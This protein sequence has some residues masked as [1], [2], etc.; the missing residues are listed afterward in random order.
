MCTSGSGVK[1]LFVCILQEKAEEAR[2]LAAA[3][4]GVFVGRVGTM[5]RAA[6]GEDM[7]FDLRL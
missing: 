6:M 1:R 7:P 5:W 2:H 4:R 3:V